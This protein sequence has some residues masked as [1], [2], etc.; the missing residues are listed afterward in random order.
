MYGD[1]VSKGVD[2]RVGGPIRRLFDRRPPRVFTI[3][4]PPDGLVVVT[5]RA[6]DADTFE[7]ALMTAGPSEVRA[8]L[9]GGLPVSVQRAPVS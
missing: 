1:P 6:A 7:A 2:G 9:A 3:E 5:V 4:L 8:L